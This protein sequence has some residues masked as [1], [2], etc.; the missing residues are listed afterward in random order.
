MGI[1]WLSPMECARRALNAVL[2]FSSWSDRMPGRRGFAEFLGRFIA[3]HAEY[4]YRNPEIKR[5]G[6][7]TNHTT[8]DYCGLLASAIALPG[9]PDSARWLNSAVG[10]LEL[11]IEQQVME[12][13]MTF[14][15]SLPYHFQVLDMFAHAALMLKSIALSPTEGY[16]ARLRGMFSLLFDVV[17][18]GGN[19]PQ[20]GDDDSGVWVTPRGPWMPSM[21]AMLYES[22]FGKEPDDK[23]RFRSRPDSGIMT[24][25]LGNLEAV[26][27]A[28]PV[29]Q[30]GLGGH[31]H[32]DL[33]QLCCS[34]AGR[35]LIVDPGTGSYNRDLGMRN[36]LRSMHAH[37]GPLPDAAPHY[38]TFHPSG[39]FDLASWLPVHRRF[40]SSG[41]H[42]WFDAGASV[43]FH[44]FEMSRTLRILD[45]ALEVTDLARYIE[46][47][48]AGFSVRLVIPSQWQLDQVS[49]REL[50]LQW[51]ENRLVFSSSVPVETS[52][53]LRSPEYD[54]LEEAHLLVLR[55]DGCE[56]LSFSLTPCSTNS[57]G[58]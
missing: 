10:G 47:A 4:V 11:C 22:I 56:P 8:A 15:G 30:Q 1:N 29:G 33:L 44:D 23:P 37:N 16:L 53:T 42:P 31:N 21:M 12:D 48:A 24:L 40:F 36:R 17:D 27:A 32:E 6:L 34:Y 20:L 54:C 52:R 57:G 43:K 3:V 41:D 9:H 35:Q 7:M 55:S 38:F 14:E 45:G 2:A 46:S 25:R 28:Q 50:R 51:D 26:L 39:P 49:P 58:Y 18:A 5:N 19:L 13:G